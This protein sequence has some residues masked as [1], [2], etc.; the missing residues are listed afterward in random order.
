MET[1][2]NSIQNSTFEIP[3]NNVVLLTVLF[4]LLSLPVCQVLLDLVLRIPMR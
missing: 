2:F 4:A 1:P 3:P